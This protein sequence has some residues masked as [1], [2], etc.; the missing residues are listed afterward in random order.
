M[1][2]NNLRKAALLGVPINPPV[3]H[4]FN[5]LLALRVTSL[6]AAEVGLNRLISGLFE[7]VWVHGR[8]VSDPAVV[9]SV[10]DAAGLN[11]AELV[12]EA[13]TRESKAR[14][15]DRT[16]RAIAAG[17]F[18]VPAMQVG[19]EIFWGYDDLP[20]LELHLA[21]EDPL[22]R[23]DLSKWLVERRPSAMRRRFR[24]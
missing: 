23:E 11:G 4:P 8:H 5:P 6:P 14:L 3:H 22:D 10:A 21:G 13:Q 16:D 1:A 18:G 9:E 12:A 2:K 19:D 17:V 24:S 15:R 20:F 7:A